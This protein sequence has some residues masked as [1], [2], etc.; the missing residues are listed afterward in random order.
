[1]WRKYC[2]ILMK[3]WKMFFEFL[4]KLFEKQ[5]RNKKWRNLE[6]IFQAIFKDH[7]KDYLAKL[8]W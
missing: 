8:S 1:M 2:E 7:F 4:R 6:M 5:T 3:M